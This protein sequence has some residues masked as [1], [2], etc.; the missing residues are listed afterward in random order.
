MPGVDDRCS[1]PTGKML[2][3]D[4]SGQCNCGAA[5]CKQNTPKCS[6]TSSA[7]PVDKAICEA[8]TQASCSQPTPYCRQDTPHQG[9]CTCGHGNLPEDISCGHEVDPKTGVP[10]R[11][12]NR[13]SADDETGTCGCGSM[14]VP[15]PF[16]TTMGICLSSSGMFTLDDV[17]STC[18]VK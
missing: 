3:D 11:T 6:S 17:T 4:G 8:C 18:Q 14:S 1:D 16:Q 10:K 15:C 7:T 12:A 5:Q 13:C 9:Y 2:L